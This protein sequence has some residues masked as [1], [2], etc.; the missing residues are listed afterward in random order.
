MKFYYY[1]LINLLVGS[2]NGYKV[3]EKILLIL[4][5]KYVNYIFYYS[6]YKGYDVEIVEILVKEILVFW[7]EEQEIIEIFFFL[8]I[9]G[10]DGILYQVFDIF[11][12]M[13]VEFFVVYILVG[14]GNDFV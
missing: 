9:V 10:G 3:V 6:E 11:Y 5:N 13:E 14:F 8:I 2:G 1:L 7:I 12:Q 4:K